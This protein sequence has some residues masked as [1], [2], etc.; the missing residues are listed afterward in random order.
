[1]LGTEVQVFALSLLRNCAEPGAL[2]YFPACISYLSFTS[3]FLTQ[4][5]ITQEIEKIF[6]AFLICIK[7]EEK[8]QGKD[9]AARFSYR[10]SH[11]TTYPFFS[12]L[13][14]SFFVT[15]YLEQLDSDGGGAG[16]CQ[17]G[18]GQGKAAQVDHRGVG[19][20]RPQQAQLIGSE[21]VATGAS[22]EQV[23]LGLLD[24]VLGLAAGTVHTLVQSLRAAL[25]LVTM[26]RIG[27]V[28]VVFEPRDHAA[29]P[30]PTAFLQ[31]QLLEAS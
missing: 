9:F 3:L 13:L 22:P 27:A 16:A 31:A 23:E 4:L 11:C 25:R 19:E 21:Y 1:M 6:C 7:L 12:A 18:I 20:C 10:N 24:A 28:G 30:V 26:A 14:P 17:F 5:Q 8:I 15:I 29:L 2:L